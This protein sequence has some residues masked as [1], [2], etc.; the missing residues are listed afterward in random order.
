MMIEV[1]VVVVVAVDKEADG[2]GT[3]FYID[4]AN[5]HARQAPGRGEPHQTL[6]TR[7][8]LQSGEEKA[9]ECLRFQLE[10]SQGS[11]D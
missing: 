8:L 10:K 7:R 6:R 9:A 11:L 2:G 1:V 4:F 3:L 5:I